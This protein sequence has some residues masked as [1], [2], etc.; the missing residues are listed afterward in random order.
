MRQLTTYERQVGKLNSD[1]MMLR[2]ELKKDRRR[3]R[4][5]RLRHGLQALKDT[6][7]LIGVLTPIVVAW[8]VIMD[9]LLKAKGL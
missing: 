5:Q 4:L 3:L 9:Q 7:I 1:V 8:V 2:R 6:V